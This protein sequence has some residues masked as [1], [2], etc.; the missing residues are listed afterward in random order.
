MNSQILLYQSSRESTELLRSDSAEL[1]DL[2]YQILSS[3]QEMRNVAEME[4]AGEHV[5]ERIMMAG[6][7]VS[8]LFFVC[9]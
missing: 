1:R 5:A 6:Q 3:Q 9:S 8:L 2:L 4:Q 7:L